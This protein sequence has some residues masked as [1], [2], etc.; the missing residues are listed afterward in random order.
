MTMKFRAHETF[1]IRKG[2]INKGMKAVHNNPEAF[3]SKDVNPMDTLGIGSN[4]VK[5]MRYWL[6]AIGITTEPKTGKRKQKFTPLGKEIYKYDRYVEELGTLF[7][8]QYRL[9]SMDELATS[10]FFF[11]NIFNMNEFTKEDFISE[12]NGYI[13]EAEGK[14]AAVRSLTDDFNCIIGTYVPR[15]KVS[16]SKVSPENNIDCPLGELGLIDIVD[17]NKKIYRKVT[18]SAENIDSWIL[19]AVIMDQAGE[20]EEVGLNE[21]LN[22]PKNI[23]KVFNLD[24]IT[25][26]DALHE[27]EKTG[28]IK[29]I[30]TAGL[31]IIRIKK[32]YS[33]ND[34]VENYY[35]QINS[36]GR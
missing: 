12:L 32:A 10:W 25:M 13:I 8:L 21:L 34:C 5:S 1:F 3:I 9:A 15:Y 27:A 29:I 33:F 30:R 16:S 18:P 11:F 2:W 31:D 20:K 23:G 4:M 14:G 26:I 36:N 28:T 6:Q 17:K 24:V 19:L 7:L 22:S 35:S